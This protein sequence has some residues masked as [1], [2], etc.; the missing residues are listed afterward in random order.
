MNRF[1]TPIALLAVA[2]GT[3]TVPAQSASTAASSA[4]E[5]ASA[6]VGS[7]STSFEKSSDSSSKKDKVAAGDY[8][9]ID[10]AGMPE[11]P[12]TLRL[13]LQPVADA[14]EDNA[15]FLYLPEQALAQNPLAVGQTV[16]ARTRPYGV[17]FAKADTG[18]AFFLVLHDD[19]HRE[20][21]SNAVTL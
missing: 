13:K 19:W 16:A 12:G 7:V 10:V 11:R 18:R 17:E 8:K 20:L 4:S 9:V 1:N 3:V 21:Q 14:N 15:F 6:S 5:G 2:L